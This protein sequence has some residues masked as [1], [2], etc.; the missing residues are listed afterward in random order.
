MEGA[1][2]K[3]LLISIPEAA[4]LIG[5][6][7]SKFYALVKAGDITL[8]KL[9]GRSLVSV[10][11]LHDYVAERLARAEAGRSRIGGSV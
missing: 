4:R 11:A 8:V 6:G 10:E 9:G 1:S 5:L 2:L 7:K 3:P